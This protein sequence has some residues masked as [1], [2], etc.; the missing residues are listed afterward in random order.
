MSAT[1][2][3]ER[4]FYEWTVWN[5]QL[6]RAGRPEQADLLHIAEEIEDMGKRE[7]R[8]LTSRLSLLIAHLLKWQVQHDRRTRSWE[9]TIRLQRREVRRILEDMPSL[10]GFAADSLPQ[11]YSDA[12]VIAV[13]ETNLPDQDFPAACLFELDQVLEEG[14]L[15]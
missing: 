1:D 15:P 7:K 14:F 3:Y 10:R 9:A 4:D 13:A 5:A 6:L 11:I 2:L 12:V 8:A